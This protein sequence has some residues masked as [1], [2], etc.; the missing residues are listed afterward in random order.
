M[1]QSE[2]AQLTTIEGTTQGNLFSQQ[3]Q[4]DVIQWEQIKEEIDELMKRIQ[5]SQK[6]GKQY[7]IKRYGKSSR[8]H[9]TDVELIEFRNYLKKQ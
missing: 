6:E 4:P 8:L 3:N 2:Y 1:N 9:L 7:L 5:W